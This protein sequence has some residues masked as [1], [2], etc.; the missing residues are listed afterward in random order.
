MNNNLLS[1]VAEEFPMSPESLHVPAMYQEVLSYL[2]L[3]KGGHIVDC[4]VGTG[5]HAEGI[6]NAIGPEGRLIGIDR[7]GDSLRMAQERLKN[8]S[9]QCQFVQNDFRH[10]DDILH[11]LAVSEADGILF[12]LGISSYQLENPE[13]GFSIKSD[14]PL[15]MR[16][17]KNSYISAYD[18][19][20]SLSEREISSILRNFGQERWHNRIANFLVKE[21]TKNPIES[22]QD[23]SNTVLKAIPHRYQHYKIHPATRTFQAFRIAVNRELEALE[24]A[25]DRCMG[26]LKKGARLC[27]I[28]FH[29][30]EDKIVKEK[31]RYFAKQE[32]LKLIVKKPLRPTDEEARTNPRSRSARLRVAERI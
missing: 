3:K 31:F 28:S 23:L 8:F 6:L 29:S 16:M 4:T 5:G 24:I 14:G 25:V 11:S 13:R 2:N 21:R 15:D 17:D 7:D 20:N 18:L 26:Y 22:T 30:L 1:D 10:I 27:V 32:K 12:D 19:V 9:N